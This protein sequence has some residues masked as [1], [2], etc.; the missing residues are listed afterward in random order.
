MNQGLTYP[1]TLQQINEHPITL[2]MYDLQIHVFDVTLLLHISSSL[3]WDAKHKPPTHRFCTPVCRH[4]QRRLGYNRDCCTC[5]GPV[6]IYHRPRATCRIQ[7]NSKRALSVAAGKTIAVS[8]QDEYSDINVL[9]TS[10]VTMSCTPPNAIL[11][12]RAAFMTAFSRSKWWFSIIPR[13]GVNRYRLNIIDAKFTESNSN[14]GGTKLTDHINHEDMGR[15]HSLHDGLCPRRFSS[16]SNGFPKSLTL[17]PAYRYVVIPLTS[18]AARPVG[19]TMSTLRPAS[20]KSFI[21]D[22]RTVDF[23]QPAEPV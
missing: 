10:P 6:R 15:G 1:E 9:L 20:C 4:Y 23:P 8:S 11:S 5:G 7:C 14:S 13:W 22:R 16:S 3:I 17:H 2:S 21:A 18:S 19:A 12:A